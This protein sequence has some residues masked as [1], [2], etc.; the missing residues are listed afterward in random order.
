MA[1][2]GAGCTTVRSVLLQATTADMQ[3]TEA[4]KRALDVMVVSLSNSS[5]KRRRE[6]E[7]ATHSAAELEAR[8]SRLLSDLALSLPLGGSFRWKTSRPDFMW[9]PLA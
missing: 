1:G 4:A 9:K 3:I 7:V 5:F 2:A 8:A 6:I